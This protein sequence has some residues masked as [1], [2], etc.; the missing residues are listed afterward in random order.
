MTNFAGT[1]NGQG[2]GPLNNATFIFTSPTL[3]LHNQIKYSV[4]YHII[5]R[6]FGEPHRI[7]VDG[8]LWA[9]F[10]K[11][12]MSPPEFTLNRFATS[13]WVPATYSLSPGLTPSVDGYIEFSTGFYNHDRPKLVITHQC[14]FPPDTFDR[15]AYLTNV[16]VETP[17]GLVYIG[18]AGGGAGGGGAREGTANNVP[19]PGGGDQP[20]GAVVV[21]SGGA[22]GNYIGNGGGGGGG[23]AGYMGGVG[24]SSLIIGSMASGGGNFIHQYTTAR[25]NLIG[26]E[27]NTVSAGNAISYD[28]SFNIAKGAGGESKQP[29]QNGIVLIRYVKKTVDTGFVLFDT[30]F[31]FG[32]GGYKT[33]LAAQEEAQKYVSAVPFQVPGTNYYNLRV[34]F[35]TNIYVGLAKPASY[36][37]P[38]GVAVDPKPF[39]RL[40]GTELD[41][42]HATPSDNTIKYVIAQRRRWPVMWL[43][44]G[45]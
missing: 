29:G 39:F 1:A 26:N 13:N 3:P 11:T 31:K 30:E 18:V 8:R 7:Y 10:S 24:Q 35:N 20:N 6:A 45:G 14:T 16:K 28:W 42:N 4:N 36:F 17:T 2:H 41:Y 44:K 27:G 33:L 15:S 40:P 34:L 23:G 43:I 12:P 5:D 19:A 32:Y 9:E 22:G 21:V 37:Y 38:N 25:T